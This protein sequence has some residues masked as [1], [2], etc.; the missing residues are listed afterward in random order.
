MEKE[1]AELSV[2][3]ELER[4]NLLGPV[5]AGQ[6]VIITAGSRGVDSMAAVLRSLTEAVK[7]RGA[8]PVILHQFA[9]RKGYASALQAMARVL[10]SDLRILGG[11]AILEDKTNAFR[12]LEA[13]PADAMH[14]HA[15]VTEA[16]AAKDADLAEREMVA[17]LFDVVGRIE[18]NLKIDLEL[19]TMC[20]VD[21]IHPTPV[22]NKTGR[23]SKRK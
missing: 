21:L 20:G 9:V 12:R 3:R 19:E 7:A 11:I 1:K 5:V 18:S 8:K 13:V 14:F 23:R 2:A 15:R 22:K 16:I 6:T 4:T 10:F 17:H